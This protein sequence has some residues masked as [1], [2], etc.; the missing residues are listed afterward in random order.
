VTIIHEC[1]RSVLLYR[2]FP[3]CLHLLSYVSTEAYM[4]PIAVSA[5]HQLPGHTEYIATMAAH[6]V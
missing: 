6:A 3:S 1:A 4:L 2:Y 5:E